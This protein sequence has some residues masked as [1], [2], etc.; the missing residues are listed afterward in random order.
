MLFG[1]IPGVILYLL[2]PKKSTVLGLLFVIA[3][4]MLTS[5]LVSGDRRHITENSK[6]YLFLVCVLSGQGACLVLLATLQALMNMMTVMASSIVCA[7]LI[8]YYISGDILMQMIMLNLTD[9]SQFEQILSYLA[10]TAGIAL[11][12][13]AL[14]ISDEE[15]GEG[16]SGFSLS[17][18]KDKAK[19]LASGV[20]Y[21]RTGRFYMIIA[22]VFS[23]IL[24]YNAYSNQLEDETA[25]KVLLGIVG[26]NLIVPVIIFLR[27]D[28]STIEGW[29]DSVTGYEEGLLS[30]GKDLSFGEAASGSQFWYLIYASVVVI[31]C[32]LMIK[33]NA[34]SMAQHDVDATLAIERYFV[35]GAI[36][37]AFETGMMTSGKARPTQALTIK[38]SFLLIG[39]ACMISPSTEST[40]MAKILAVTSGWAFSGLL[41]CIAVFVN[42]E[43]GTESF[44]ILY[45]SFLAAGGFGY[46][47]FNEVL[48][49]QIFS[50]HAETTI[51]GELR[52]K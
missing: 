11:V 8:G 18:L 50:E 27:L 52:L 36:L 28:Q 35:V 45:G 12:L 44:G 25:T 19:T 42:F 5:Q 40:L 9:E 31:G 29:V 14:V 49:G 51:N 30:K 22:G 37:S 7:I 10:I 34:R 21:S 26:L 6:T 41:V 17:A 3:S 33:E 32:P 43:Y 2:K 15:D 23:V 1:L 16:G 13:C 20:L 38:T 47:A 48:F 24:A 39:C 46:Y 4:L